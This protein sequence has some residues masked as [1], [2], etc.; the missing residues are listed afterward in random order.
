MVL[1]FQ[2]LDLMVVN[3]IILLKFIMLKII[4]LHVREPLYLDI[5]PHSLVVIKNM[6]NL[7][8]TKVFKNKL[9]TIWLE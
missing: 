4:I 2:D 1:Y 8:A 6:R 5:G 7:S 3:N 9:K